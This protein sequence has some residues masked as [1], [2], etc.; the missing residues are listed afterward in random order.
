M[1]RKSIDGYNLHFIDAFMIIMKAVVLVAYLLHTVSP[2][3]M[4]KFKTDKFYFTSVFVLMGVMR[5][6][7]I[8][9]L[10]ENSGSPTEIFLK[11]L[12]IKMS[13]VGWI[14]SFF[15]LVYV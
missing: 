15:L 1:R 14:I 10:E 13:I 8:T 3:I 2:E 9:M 5:Y 12:F 4:A 7:Q 6:L 11:D